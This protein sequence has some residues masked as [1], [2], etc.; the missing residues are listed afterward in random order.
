LSRCPIVSPAAGELSGFIRADSD[1]LSGD[2]QIG[3]DLDKG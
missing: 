1:R 2:R 3:C